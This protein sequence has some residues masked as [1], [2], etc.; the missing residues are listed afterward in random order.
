M[1]EDAHAAAEALAEKADQQAAAGAGWGII[2]DRLG[3]RPA[4]RHR[5]MVAISLLA[6]GG[7]PAWDSRDDHEEPLETL[8]QRLMGIDAAASDPIA[9]GRPWLEHPPNLR[10]ELAERR[11]AGALDILGAATRIESATDAQLDHDRDLAQ[12]MLERAIPAIQALESDYGR[13][14]GGLASISAFAKPTKP[15]D[16]SF[17]TLLALDAL[18]QPETVPPAA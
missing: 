17:L 6:L 1:H 10:Q 11:A 14:V 13:D 3:R 2:G 5:A 12:Q 18:A 7:E 16:F 8:F 9:N 4:D 15:G